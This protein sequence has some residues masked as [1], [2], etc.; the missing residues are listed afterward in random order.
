MTLALTFSLVSQHFYPATQD[1]ARISV[2]SLAYLCA[3]SQDQM[4]KVLS[5]IVEVLNLEEFITLKS[6]AAVDLK[7]IL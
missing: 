4:K 3:L 2:P 5:Q 1:H 7:D 6:D